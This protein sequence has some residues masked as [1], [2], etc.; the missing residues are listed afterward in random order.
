MNKLMTLMAAV[1]MLALSASPLYAKSVNCDDP[2]RDLQNTIDRAKVG[3]EIF[4]SG[5]C[6][7]N[8]LI[9]KDIKLTGPATLSA[10]AGGESVLS[11]HAA[12]VDFVDIAIDAVG[13]QFGLE[14]EGGTI[15]GSLLVV[16]NALQIGI[17]VKG[18]SFAQISD[19]EIS[20][21]PEG[22][23][24]S[25]SSSIALSESVVVKNNEFFGITLAQS[26]SGT[27]E[28]SMI[29][30]NGQGINVESN[31]SLRINGNIISNN[32]FG[33]HISLNGYVESFN[34]NTIQNNSPG[35]DVLC[36]TRSTFRVEVPQISVTQTQGIS[37]DCLVTNP[38]F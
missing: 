9:N 2:E 38:I 32:T 26:S 10:T 33:L 4:I 3:E 21:N 5:T 30:G 28:S 29:V 19:S 34:P 31:S 16:Q 12:D 18:T 1:A 15:R 8:F 17:F 14:V 13:N 35:S 7:G 11:I 20:Y 27:I 24:V 23:N 6:T 37:A 36:D 22:I 25:Q